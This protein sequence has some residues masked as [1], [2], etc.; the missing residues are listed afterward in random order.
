[1]KKYSTFI[2]ERYQF[3]PKTH[4]IIL[5]YSL[6]HDETFTETIQLPTEG[7]DPDALDT[8]ELDAAMFA[9]HL[10]GGIS[11]YKT[12]IP[13]EIV[14]KSGA[15]NRAQAKF[16]T[17]VYENGLGEFFYK[18]QIDFRNLI[19]FPAEG[20]SKP[21]NWKRR[22]VVNRT[23]KRLLVPIGG[24]KDSI[25]TMELLKKS[26]CRQTLLRMEPH[27]IIDE[28]AHISGLPMMTVKRTLSPTLFELN[29]QG[30]LNGHVPI[31]AYLSVLSS[32]IALLYGYDAVVMSNE[33]SADYGN[34]MFHSREINHQWSK[35][36]GAEKL[37]ADY[38]RD[39][40]SRDA[41]YFSLLRPLTELHVTK[42]FTQHPEYFES[43]TSCNKNWKIAGDGPEGRWCGECPKC[44]FVFVLMAAFLDHETLQNMFGSILF[45]DESLRPLYRQL[46]GIEGTKPFEC[47]GTPEE[48]KAAFLLA[49][50]R[51][52]LE[53]TAIMRMF[54]KDVLPGIKQPK[55]LIQSQFETGAK[56]LIPE[57][58]LPLLP[59]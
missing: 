43:F 54:V 12:C 52:D 16:W 22:N 2:F 14:I 21:I 47:V 20:D 6:D 48:T 45:D 4:R 10:I 9:M 49:H 3:N 40:V 32:V 50:E 24:G 27:P 41:G 31:T 34:V 55:K 23:E 28:V 33:G 56:H 37:I 58:Y 8:H 15:L 39:W 13:R 59:S 19:R 46:L 5:E 17:S 11:Y 42:L 30:A 38:L 29:K 36:L 1:M 25:V 51:G 18:N 44:A 26:G 7:L 35:S 57:P 53:D